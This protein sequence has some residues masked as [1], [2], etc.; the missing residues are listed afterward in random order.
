MYILLLDDPSYLNIL[1]NLSR[2]LLWT[3]KYSHNGAIR[4]VDGLVSVQLEFISNAMSGTT[5][6][7]GG[8][9]FNRPFLLTLRSFLRQGQFAYIA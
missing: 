3:W 2:P 4:A 5:H 7:C 6:L 1:G 9:C 8:F